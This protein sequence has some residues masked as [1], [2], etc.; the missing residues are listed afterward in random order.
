MMGQRTKPIKILQLN[1]NHSNPVCHAILNAT[2]KSFDIILLTE[3][4]FGPIGNDQRGPVSLT[5]WN[6]V[7]P[8][9]PIPEDLTPRT[10]AYYRR[11]NDFHVTLRSDL[12]SDADIQILQVDQPPNPP[13]LIINVYNQRAGDDRN[14][15]SIDRLRNIAIPENLPVIISGDFNT[16]HPLWAVGEPNP[17]RRAEAL[18]DWL[19]DN[20]MTMCNDKGAPTFLSHCG[21]ATSVLDLTFAN[22]IARTLNST[23]EWRIAPE[24]A[25]GSDHYALTWTIDYG[26]VAL[27]NITAQQFRWRNL[28]EDVPKK[29]KATYKSESEDRAWA[30]EGLLNKKPAAQTLDIAAQEL[31][32]AMQAAMEAHIPKRKDSIH[33]RPWWTPELTQAYDYLHD[34]RKSVQIFLDLDGEEHAD[35]QEFI[36]KTKNRLKRLTKEAKRKWIEDELGKASPDDVWALTRW[37]KGIRQY[38]SPPHYISKPTLPCPDLDSSGQSP[39]ISRVL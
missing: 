24:L 30:F 2:V 38:P 3:P 18:V 22:N 25:C 33:A 15:W 13:T 36:R 10:M 11:R 6:P 12:I 34:L 14:S 21:R 1:T 28:K 19:T 29:W 16:H 31:H 32:N 27:D 8:L 5:G 26:A 17:D 23:H 4:W 39:R 37:P 7:L 35:T 20:R 9:Q